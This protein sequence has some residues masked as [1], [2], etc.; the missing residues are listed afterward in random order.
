MNKDTPRALCGICK[1][2]CG[3]APEF[4]TS[5]VPICT[6]CVERI[7]IRHLARLVKEEIEKLDNPITDE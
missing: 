7:A 3:W 2:I 1:T 6:D 4:I 5:G